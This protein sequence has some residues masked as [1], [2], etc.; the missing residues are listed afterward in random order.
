[1]KDSGIYSLVIKLDNGQTIK[2]GKLRKQ[3]FKKGFYVYTGSALNGL[4]ARIAR[5]KRKTKK[6]FWHI[7]Y[8]LASKQAKIFKVFT[9]QTNKRMECEFNRIIQTSPHAKAI[10]KGFGCSDCNCKS[11][12]VYFGE[13]P[14][15][16]I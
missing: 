6:L 11:H 8:M 3:K 2:I 14:A 5:H 9:I 4:E 10:V 16:K 15:G 12:L 13:N 1:M 7:D